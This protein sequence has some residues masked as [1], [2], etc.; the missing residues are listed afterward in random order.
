MRRA[1]RE[2]RKL[3]LH[4][5]FMSQLSAIY[6]DEA[7]AYPELVK[8]KDN[9]LSVISAEEKKFQKTLLSGER[10]M[11]R[12]LEKAGEIT[13]E[14]AFYF[15]ETFGFPIELTVEFL[16][17]NN[18]V[19]V[20]P[21][22]FDK[23]FQK[24]S[25]KSRTATAGKFQGGLADHSEKTTALHSTAHLMLAGLRE[26]LGE[27]VHQK[28]SNI[29]PERIRFDFSHD[30]KMTEEQRLAVE[31]YVNAAIEADAGM[32]ICEMPKE[33]AKSEG[34]EGSFWEKYPDV[35]KVYIFQD[36]TGKIWSKELCGGP[37]IERTG[38]LKQYGE[39]QVKK[40]ESSSAGVRRVKAILVAQQ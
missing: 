19:L 26:I 28:G 5:E 13:G 11:R 6:I 27:H 17:E 40:E 23:A 35:V 36:K 32:T 16:E 29:T 31:K 2:A 4:S 8:T 1:I 24:H 9:I 18:T 10:E 38:L 39:F 15:Y 33:Q 20:N 7:S 37:H 34:V 30:Q 3:G 25:E 22:G 12:H 14:D 21:V